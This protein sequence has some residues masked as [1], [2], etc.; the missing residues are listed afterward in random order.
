MRGIFSARAWNATS[1][2]DDAISDRV[3][4]ADQFVQA[5]QVS[6]GDVRVTVSEATPGMAVCHQRC[7]VVRVRYDVGRDP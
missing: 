7:K 2:V 3:T 5:G 1:D 4:C 6:G